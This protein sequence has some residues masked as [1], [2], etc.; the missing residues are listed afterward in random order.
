[1]NELL[2]ALSMISD[3]AVILALLVGSIGGVIVGA[4]PGVGPPVAIAIILPATFSLDPLIGLSAMLGIYGSAMYGGALPA[5]LINTPG[6]AVNA[7]TTF[8]GYPMTKRGEARQALMLAYTAS[9]VGGVVGVAA[10]M[11]LSPVLAKI[12]PL[13]GAREIFL[14]ALLGLILVILV[15]R[16]Q[17]AA[18]GMLAGLGIFISTVGLDRSTYSQ[19]Y[20]FD[21]SWLS[22]GFDL[23]VVVLGLFAISQA[24]VLL[25]A[26]NEQPDVK[27]VTGRIGEGFGRIFKHM[28]V[29]LVGSGCGVG[30]GIIPGVGEFTAQ[31]LSYSHARRNSKTPEMFGKGAPE[32]LVAAESANN[33]VPGAAL[34][35]LLALG[36][37]GEALT[38]MM[39]SVFYV[40]GV[41]P[42]PRLFADQM[43]FVLA[44]YIALIIMNVLVLGFLLVSTNALTRLIKIPT[45]FLG[46][47]ILLLSF[48]GVYSL[49]NSVTDCAV[50][51]GVGL[52]GMILRRL[53]LPIVPIILGI[54]LGDIMEQRLKV[55]AVQIHTPWDIFNRPISAV[56]VILIGALLASAIWN[57]LRPKKQTNQQGETNEKVSS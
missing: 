17:V 27:P 18:A 8:D 13:F 4:I 24:F 31:F 26:P 55:A 36:I 7:L 51:A 25:L 46:V 21:Q 2:S 1:M 57:H 6:T 12:A 50:A 23:I 37:P 56:L 45:R 42:G 44:L 30:M 15:H 10:L 33:A 54:V 28:R 14:V 9:F 19:R 22:S 53:N 35:P 29:A 43:D 39:L 38:A 3:P 11:I 41:I 49:R 32:G 40:H 5:I 20:T 16:G 48:V 47:S 34:V 52:F